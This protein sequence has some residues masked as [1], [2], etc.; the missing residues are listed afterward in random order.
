MAAENTKTSCVNHPGAAA[1][2]FCP[3]CMASLCR[4]CVTLFPTPAG[5]TAACK[6]C[7][8]KAASL[9]DDDP[10][11]NP[12]HAS[13]PLLEALPRMLA[14]PL[15]NFGWATVCVGGAILAVVDFLGSGYSVGV[16]FVV[17]VAGYLMSYTVAI[18]EDSTR[19][20]D[21]MPEWP[22]VSN[23]W[24]GIMEPLIKLLVVAA[25]SFGP[26]A[27]CF[28]VGGPKIVT[29]LLVVAG[30]IYYPM[31]ILAVVLFESYSAA[32]PGIV[33]PSIRSIADD[34]TIVG[35]TMV[36]ILFIRETL[37]RW[38]TVVPLAGPLLTGVGTVYFLFF[39]AHLIG[40]IY[41]LNA[42]QLGWFE[43]VEHARPS[44]K[45]PLAED[46]FDS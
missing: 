31:A 6:K 7:G 33:I 44:Q 2:W 28:F 10:A 15:R 38:I 45:P 16:A 26:A 39:Q 25:V 27:I 29:Q 3:D 19:G 1:E 34:Y 18:I 35:C 43:E 4:Q 30:A 41:R 12:L 21:S 32:L 36:V 5:R 40:S 13:Q 22:D 37:L 14:Y 24:D 20:S 23:W 11:G 8:A 9:M 42:A 17:L 46:K